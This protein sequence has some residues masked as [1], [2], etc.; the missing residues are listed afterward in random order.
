MFKF[1]AI[2]AGLLC[3]LAAPVAAE[4]FNITQVFSATHWHMT[5]GIQTFMDEVSAA[6]NGEI[7]FE[8]YHAGQLGKESTTV[9]NSGLAQMGILVPGYEVEKLPLTSV[10]ELPG[11]HT[12]ACEGTMQYWELAKEGGALFEEEYKKLGV[13]PLYVMV[14]TPYEVQTNSAV[15][16]SVDDM[17]GLKLRANGALAKA[18]DFLGGVP[19]QVTSPEFYDALARGVVDGGMWLSGSTRLVGLE[20]VLNHTVKGTSMGAGSTM[21]AISEKVWQGLDEETQKILMEA[22]E[23]TT[24]HM[25]EYLDRSGAEEEKWLVENGKL[26]LH[27]LSP[28]QAAVWS[29]AIAPVASQWADDMN[30]KGRAGTKVLDAYKAVAESM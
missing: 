5:E 30:S 8:V 22:G 16:E 17:K 24:R 9:V 27:V 12:S 29:E 25:C 19:M 21:F 23:K 10:V 2:S 28:E 15:V 1:T 13:R 7:T 6:S 14:L 20:D 3:A 4:K 26:T 11:F 18:V